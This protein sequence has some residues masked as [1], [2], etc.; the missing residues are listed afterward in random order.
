MLYKML[1]MWV[2][3]RILTVTFFGEFRARF[4]E[5]E[6]GVGKAATPASMPKSD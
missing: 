4:E 6:G 1:I 3:D 5:S 2:V